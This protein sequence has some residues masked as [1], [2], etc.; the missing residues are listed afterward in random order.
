M[1]AGSRS[2]VR[3]RNS[4]S[5]RMFVI[6]YGEQKE[7]FN[8]SSSLQFMKTKELWRKVGM[9]TMRSLEMNSFSREMKKVTKTFSCK[10]TLQSFSDI[11][12]RVELLCMTKSFLPLSGSRMWKDDKSS[13][14][15]K[16]KAAESSPR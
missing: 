16:R 6:V 5:V 4:H 10:Q 3:A 13:S 9:T 12:I 14:D 8:F 7:F 11:C 2:L 1:S 15:T